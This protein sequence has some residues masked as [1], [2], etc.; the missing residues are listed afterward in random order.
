[1]KEFI[2]LM[3]S[4]LL[5]GCN[6]SKEVT[7]DNIST[8]VVSV[9]TIEKTPGYTVTHE[10]SGMIQPSNRASL[11][12]EF[13][14]KI[15]KV[16]VNTGDVIQQGDPLIRLDT[17]ILETERLQLQAQKNQYD[18]QLNLIN[19]NLN[20]QQ[21]LKRKGFSADAEI[22]SLI[23]QKRVLTANQKQLS[24]T[25][26][27]LNLRLSKSTLYAPFAG[28]IANRHASL[29]DV[30]NLGQQTISLISSDDL[31]ATVGIPTSVIPNLKDTRQ[32]RLR[33][34]NEYYESELS[35]QAAE[36]DPLSRTQLM[37]FT[38]PSDQGLLAGQLAYL[39]VEQYH[40][41]SGF[42]VPLSALTDGVRGVWNLFA[43]DQENVIERRTINVLHS[44]QFN[45]YV[46][47][48]IN[49]G[50]TIVARGIHRIVPGQH[51]TPRFDQ[52]KGGE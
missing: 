37:T 49:A 22:D 12:F 44:D 21:T 52:T 2:P 14:G 20:R 26:S 27:T 23:S 39:S 31:E 8:P 19:A 42:W 46:S 30:V 4:I 50:D 16:W 51:V 41:A 36:I 29:G 43:L 11:G 40:D 5:V 24:A 10:L 1:M 35:R 7:S 45:A 15:N 6:S 32:F 47:G 28:I 9:L 48:A 33:V 18:A 17:S 3:L 13:S 38:V 34:E 25:L